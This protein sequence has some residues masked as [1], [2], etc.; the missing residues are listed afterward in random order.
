M[1][2][3]LPNTN[4]SLEY[5]MQMQ[6]INRQVLFILYKKRKLFLNKI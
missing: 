3:P 4:L 6:K 2:I 5:L 1:K